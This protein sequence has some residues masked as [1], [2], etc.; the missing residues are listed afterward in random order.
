[1]QLRL[2]NLAATV[3]LVLCVAALALWVRSH[4]GGD[5][6]YRETDDGA[7][8]TWRTVE[9]VWWDGNICVGHTQLQPVAGPSGQRAHPVRS[10]WRHAR[11]NGNA[12]MDGPLMVD[13]DRSTFDLLPP[14]RGLTPYG[15]KTL[16]WLAVRLWPMVCA[17]AILPSLW[18]RQL[19]RRRRD[20][21]A[22]LCPA[23]GY[24]LRATPDRW[25]ECGALP[26][27]PAAREAA[28]H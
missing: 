22:G 25:P 24:D 5:A 10:R 9:L 7:G 6:I 16:R 12:M 11:I 23:C 18:A 4:V 19:A 15:S 26:R 14:E 2:F 8:Q 1:M 21:R 13:W 27:H 3:S 20:A 28:L 17:A